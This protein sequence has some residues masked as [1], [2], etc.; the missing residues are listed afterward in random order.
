MFLA[1][2]PKNINDQK[3]LNKSAVS[4]VVGMLQVNESLFV[5]SP[6][7]VQKNRPCLFFYERVK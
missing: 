6:C 5:K 4:R 1:R 3:Q 2:M 7:S